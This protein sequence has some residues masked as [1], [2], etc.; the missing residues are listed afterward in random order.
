[1]Q[2]TNVYAVCVCVC[3]HACCALMHL[4]WRT[5]ACLIFHHK[6]EAESNHTLIKGRL[7]RA[8]PL[9]GLTQTS[10]HTPRNICSLGRF[11]RALDNQCV[12][13]CV[14][15]LS[16]LWPSDTQPWTSKV[17]DFGWNN[18]TKGNI[19]AQS[20]HVESKLSCS[21]DGFVAPGEPQVHRRPLKSHGP[22]VNM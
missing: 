7:W 16:N 10:V 15:Q 1:M 21:S 9:W 19:F 4:T 8:L 6:I 2:P 14:C 18:A 20:D 3:V 22:S 11:V 5:R 17:V 12:C 13:V